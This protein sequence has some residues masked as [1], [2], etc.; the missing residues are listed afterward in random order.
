MYRYIVVEYCWEDDSYDA[1]K[2]IIGSYDSL[3]AA[4]IATGIYIKKNVKRM[5]TKYRD[6]QVRVIREKVFFPI[7][8]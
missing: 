3:K 5:K 2:K 8:D 7:E 1:S 6:W 4:R